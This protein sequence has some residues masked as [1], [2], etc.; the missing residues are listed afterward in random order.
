MRHW[1]SP[2]FLF[3]CF[4]NFFPSAQ[5]IMWGSFCHFINRTLVV[6]F[7]LFHF[8]L[9]SRTLIGWTYFKVTMTVPLLNKKWLY[10]IDI[11]LSVT[12]KFNKVHEGHVKCMWGQR[13]LWTWAK[14]QTPECG[15]TIKQGEYSTTYQMWCIRCY[16]RL[17]HLYLQV[18]EEVPCGWREPGGHSGYLVDPPW[19]P[20]KGSF[21]KS[22]WV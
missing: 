7:Y 21:K 19:T 4:V 14:R 12:C 8:E 6:F 17:L 18:P 9:V 2:T 13:G 10:V 11:F 3:F 1:F 16:L 22:R 20:T 5:L 15:E